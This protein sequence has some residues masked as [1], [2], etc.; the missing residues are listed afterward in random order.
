MANVMRLMLALGCAACGLSAQAT[1]QTVV[2]FTTAGAA[3]EIPATL[4]KPDGMGP[5]PAVLILHDC[6]GL[7]ARSSGAPMRW[8]SELLQQGYVVLIPDSFSPRGFADG[9]CFIPGSQSVSAGIY[10][11][12]ADAYG[13]LAL[14]RTLPY[15]DAKRIGVMG[16]SHGGSTT[17]AAMFATSDAGDPLAAAKRDGFAAAIALYPGCAARYGDWWTRR[18]GAFG[19]PAGYVGVYKPIAPL[20]ILIGE[21]DDWTPADPCRRLA[22]TSQAAG[23]PVEIKVYP[24]SH[25]SFDSDRP[26]RYDGARNNPSSPSGRGATTGGNSAAWED[27][28]NQVSAF[29][30]LHLK[31][32][33]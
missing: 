6:S 19:P 7:G 24:D 3:T 16:G 31:Q 21:R 32:Q 26:V 14:L 33:R 11:R 27:A 29:F 30:A 28:K 20:L 22:E 10:V 12:A 17:L 5:F 4:I 13:A 8:A 18:M 9:V 15:V 23:L 25:H 2:A 1:E